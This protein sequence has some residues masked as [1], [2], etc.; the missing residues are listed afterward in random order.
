MTLYTTSAGSRD[1]RNFYLSQSLAHLSDQAG[2][3]LFTIKSVS[4]GCSQTVFNPNGN[5]VE[6]VVE[7]TMRSSTIGTNTVD[8]QFFYDPY[9][10]SFPP[11]LIIHGLVM[12]PSLSDIGLDD[13]WDHEDPANLTKVLGKLSRIMQVVFATP[14]SVPYTRA[15]K[16]HQAKF[17]AKV[18]FTISSLVPNDVTAVQSKIEMLSPFDYPDLLQSITEIGKQETINNFVERVSRKISDHFEKQ[19]RA[20]QLRKEFVEILTATFRPQLLECDMVHHKFASF[21]F[22][23]PREKPKAEATAIAAF[24]ISDNFPD[25]YPKLTLTTP[26]LPNDSFAPTPPPEV[27]PISRYSPRW[28]A[29]RIVK[30]VWEQ[31]WEEI[32]HYYGKITHLPTSSTS[33]V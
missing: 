7:I 6:D 30:E 14:F 11:D 25:E 20:R 9:D 19:T 22:T 10:W 15:G 24:Y 31:L 18:Q 12:K 29:E 33:L 8:L 21:I 32:P 3:A 16:K 5:P 26:I 13:S 27:I 17:V 1:N 23:V 2:M 28:S 4:L